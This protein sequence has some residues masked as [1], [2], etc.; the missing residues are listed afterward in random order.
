MAD[1]IEI[2]CASSR[3]FASKLALQM[4]TWHPRVHWR[5]KC[6]LDIRASGHTV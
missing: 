3:T 5:L 1:W 6:Q 2:K 4:P